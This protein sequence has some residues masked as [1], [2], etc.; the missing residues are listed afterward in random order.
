MQ[1]RT[2]IISRRDPAYDPYG[3]M[4]NLQCQ[5]NK[6]GGRRDA[7]H[8]FDADAGSS[9]KTGNRNTPRGGRLGDRCRGENER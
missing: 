2:A 5:R 1:H 4:I 6:K 8:A 9:G 3:G 7:G